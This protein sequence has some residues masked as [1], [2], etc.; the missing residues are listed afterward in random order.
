MIAEEIVDVSSGM[1][2]YVVV[3]ILFGISFNIWILLATIIFS[4]IPDIDY[5]PFFL[6]R[7]RYGWT[8]HWLVHYPLLWIGIAALISIR[9]DYWAFLLGACAMAHFGHDA[10]SEQGM[11][12][13]W[14]FSKT[15]YR[16]RIFFKNSEEDYQR[17]H[18]A[19]R[20]EITEREVKDEIEWRVGHKKIS[21]GKIIFFSFA[22]AALGFYLYFSYVVLPELEML[23]R[24]WF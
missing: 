13:L 23:G 16:W 5:I 4:D 3:S 10:R 2:I 19:R 24:I 11:A 14:P 1:I 20:M 8:S 17:I 15:H 18:S 9:S 21:K 12:I 6:W 22:C 7:K